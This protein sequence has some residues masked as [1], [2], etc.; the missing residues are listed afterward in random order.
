MDLYEHYLCLWEQGLV[1]KGFSRRLPDYATRSWFGYLQKALPCGSG[2]FLDV[3]A[4]DGRLSLVLLTAG[5]KKGV[6][7]EVCVDRSSWDY[8]C[9]HYKNFHLHEATLQD[10]MNYLDQK[11]DFVVIAEVFEH[12]PSTDV[13]PFLH[14]LSQVVAPGG[15]VFLTT[16]N[17]YVQ[18]PAQQS[19]LWY[20]RCSYGHYKHYTAAELTQLLTTAGFCVQRCD[21]ECHCLKKVLYD[22]CFYHVSRWDERLSSSKRLPAYAKKAYRVISWPAIMIIRLYFRALARVVFFIESYR[23][24]EQS[25]ATIIMTARKM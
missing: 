14:K 7:L 21:F 3:G 17:F 12:I 2:A 23:S 22:K 6:A 8:I 20:E 19:P 5:Y 18:G 25:S 15:T 11:F 13:E 4:G 16:P 24:S 9:T 1:G 10:A